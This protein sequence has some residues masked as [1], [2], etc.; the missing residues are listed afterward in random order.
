[1]ARSKFLRP[2]DL[3]GR[4]CISYMRWSTATQ[5]EGDSERRQREAHNRI[6]EYFRLVPA[7]IMVERGLEAVAD[8]GLSASKGHHVKRGNLGTLM[9]DVEHGEVAKGTVLAIEA[10]DRLD[11]RGMLDVFE[12]LR[13]LIQT[14]GLLIV[15]GDLTIWGPAEIDS[16]LNQS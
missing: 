8:R 15:T 3:Y 4:E 7:R 16:P 10:F 5:S 12:V 9:Q 13:T 6:F 14:H 2:E 1:M 11:R